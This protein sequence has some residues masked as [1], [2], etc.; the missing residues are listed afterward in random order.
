MEIVA[1]IILVL[2]FALCSNPQT[3]TQS[4]GGADS[5]ILEKAESVSLRRPS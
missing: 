2:K 4:V 1:I 3:G 5:G